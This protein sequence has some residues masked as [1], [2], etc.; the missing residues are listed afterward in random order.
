MNDILKGILFGL[1]VLIVL[2]FLSNWITAN[3]K[4]TNPRPTSTPNPTPANPQA[5]PSTS[6]Q[7]I[8]TYNACLASNAKLADN[9]PCVTCVQDP[10][11]QT[12]QPGVIFQG[13]CVPHQQ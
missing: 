12:A 4:T 7:N 9:T 1:V 3:A 11:T 13:L 2:L 8:I 5:P 6:D 10:S